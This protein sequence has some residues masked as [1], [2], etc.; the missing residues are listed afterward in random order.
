MIN[1][2]INNG[3]LTHIPR[4]YNGQ[5]VSQEEAEK[6]IIANGGKDPE[7]GLHI[8]HGGDPE[9][10]S[11]NM[12]I[13]DYDPRAPKQT[14]P[15]PVPAAPVV[16]ENQQTE[17]FQ[18]KELSGPE[19]MWELAKET[20]LTEEILT[21]TDYFPDEFILHKWNQLVA[22]KLTEAEEPIYRLLVGEVTRRKLGGN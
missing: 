12:E 14:K 3:Q 20:G 1:P 7:T 15:K 8:A 18:E 5:L 13:V 22:K 10:R 21:N 6:I 19:A 2:K 4:I 9:A 17:M 11:K 16:E